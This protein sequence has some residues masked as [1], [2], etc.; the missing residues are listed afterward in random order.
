MDWTS[1]LLCVDWTSRLP[2]MDWTQ[3]HTLCL[4]VHLT[5]QLYEWDLSSHPAKKRRLW[6]TKVLP[7]C[8]SWPIFTVVFVTILSVV[9]SVHVG[10]EFSVDVFCVV[11][12]LLRLVFSGGN[13]KERKFLKRI[14]TCESAF[15][16]CSFF[17]LF[18][19]KK[20]RKRNRTNSKTL[21]Q[22]RRT[23]E[24]ISARNK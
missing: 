14:A 15:V 10:P 1:P 11:I 13:D 12:S 5:Q 8:Y 24:L 2:C 17:F 20:E 6:F 23:K 22:N 9:S 4:I 7:V 18:F 16:D 3:H 21:V 19:F